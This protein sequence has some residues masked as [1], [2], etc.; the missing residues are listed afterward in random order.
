[1]I[2]HSAVT[3]N[4]SRRF[5]VFQKNNLCVGSWPYLHHLWPERGP[6]VIQNSYKNQRVSAQIPTQNNRSRSASRLL[7]ADLRSHCLIVK[8]RFDPQTTWLTDDQ[9]S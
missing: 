5:M 3:A 9:D 2:E 1:M 6:F 4:F 8:E 7:V